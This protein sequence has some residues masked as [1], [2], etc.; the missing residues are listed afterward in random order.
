MLPQLG[1]AP[2]IDAEALYN[3][4]TDAVAD[5]AFT[6]ILLPKQQQ[7]QQPTGNQLPEAQQV[8]GAV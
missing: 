4:I 3:Y 8:T 1:A 6:N 7:Q 2:G 5:P